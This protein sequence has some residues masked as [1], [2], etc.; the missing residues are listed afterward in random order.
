MNNIA[1]VV[2]L[3]LITTAFSSISILCFLEP[4]TR[5]KHDPS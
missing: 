2:F 4:L 1:G 5:R 3:V